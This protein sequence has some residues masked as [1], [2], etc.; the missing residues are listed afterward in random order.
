MT[1]G[2][3]LSSNRLVEILPI[4]VLTLNQVD[5][6]FAPPFIEFFRTR[7]CV[8]RVFIAFEP[9]KKMDAITG[10]ES[11]NEIILVFKHASH[12]VTGDT[13]VQRPMFA[14]GHDIHAVHYCTCPTVPPLVIPG[15]AAGASP[16]IHNFNAT[17]LS[18]A[19]HHG[20]VAFPST[21]GI[22]DSGL[23]AARRPGM[24]E[25][26]NFRISVYTPPIP[27]ACSNARRTSGGWP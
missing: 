24:T 14:A 11:T 16:E 23:A 13:N 15:R 21:V 17:D 10:C 8:H 7:D 9:D 1:K 4:R 27:I 3:G 6:P 12:Q 5:L 22:M 2:A 20:R 26:V 25:S 18:F 19:A